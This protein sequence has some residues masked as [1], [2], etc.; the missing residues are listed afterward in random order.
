MSVVERAFELAREGKVRNLPEL[1]TTL[2]RARGHNGMD[3]Q[4]RI[5]AATRFVSSLWN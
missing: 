3:I 5:L 1:K 4:T 2:P